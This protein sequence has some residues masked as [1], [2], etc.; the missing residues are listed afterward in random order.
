MAYEQVYRQKFI[1][2]TGYDM[3]T[4]SFP[5]QAYGKIGNFNA[6][7]I[8]KKSLRAC[9]CKCDDYM[10]LWIHA[11]PQLNANLSKVYRLSE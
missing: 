8:T 7:N 6:S 9:S 2:S 4:Y 10:Q 11:V 1:I 3:L 5:T